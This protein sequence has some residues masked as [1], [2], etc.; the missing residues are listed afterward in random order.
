L[1][2]KSITKQLNRFEAGGRSTLGVA[3]GGIGSATLMRVV[4]NLFGSPIQKS[5]SFNLPVVGKVGLIDVFNYLIYAGGL[6][7]SKRGLIA[8]GADKVAAG[9]LPSIGPIN[10]P[11]SRNL[12]QQASVQAGAAGAPL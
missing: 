3:A 1:V 9:G 5:L 12:S 7:P 6:K 4:D 11:F 2:L 10:L 8:V